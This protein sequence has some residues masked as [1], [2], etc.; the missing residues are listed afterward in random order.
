ML[1]TVDDDRRRLTKPSAGLQKLL[2]VSDRLGRGTPAARYNVTVSHSHQLVWFRVAKVGTRSVFAALREAGV[3][4]DL[5]EPF[6]VNVPRALTPGYVRAAF[7]RQPIDRFLSGWQSTV[8]KLNHFAFDP[9]TLDA[10]QDLS[11]FVEWFA[12]QDPVTCDPHF[13]LQSALI[14]EEPIDLLGRMESFD[15]DLDRLFARIGAR[16][17]AR[18]RMN[19][20]PVPPPALTAAETRLLTARYAPDFGRFGYEVS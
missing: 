1:R 7:V 11:T 9:A 5:E 4:L 6:G 15:A 13:R 10:M 12:A 16:R 14:P 19:A 3:S 8:V 20:S 17:A 18:P 2:R